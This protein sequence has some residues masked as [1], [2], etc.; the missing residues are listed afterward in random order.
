MASAVRPF[1]G[2]SRAGLSFLAEL[3][4]HNDRAWFAAHKGEYVRL[5]KEPLEALCIALAER[6]AARGIPLE[7]DPVRSPFRI[8]RDV[9]FSRDKTPYKTYVSA[10]FPYAGGSRDGR[11][12]LARH[13]GGGGYFSLGPGEIYVGGGV[14]HPDRAWLHEWR[15]A[16]VA[17]SARLHAVID[18]PALIREFGALDGERLTRVPP[19]FPPDHPDASLL[20]LK[21]VTFGRP[22][23]DDEAFSADLPDTLA[24]AFAVAVPLLDLLAE[25]PTA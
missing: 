15:A 12:R 22:L 13:A 23:S 3:R 1:D 10:S 7:A 21:D 19:G 18:A 4:E 25:L 11:V 2:F 8:Y 6:F 17:E 14:W 5:L 16:V 24:A 9:R 20:R